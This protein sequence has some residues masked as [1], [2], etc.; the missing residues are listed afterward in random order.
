MSIVIVLMLRYKLN[1]FVKS[2]I[3]SIKLQTNLKSQCFNDQIVWD[4]EFG[5]CDFF[6]ICVLRFGI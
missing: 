5:Y 1:E 2:Q 4:F 3:P 6:D